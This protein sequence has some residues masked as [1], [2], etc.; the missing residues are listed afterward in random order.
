LAAG[1]DWIEAD[2][3]LHYGRLVARHDRSIWRLPITFSRTSVSLS[4]APPIVL[5]TLLHATQSTPARLL[6]DL[7]GR[8]ARLPDALVDLLRAQDAFDRVALCGQEWAL[9]DRAR[10]L[11]PHVKVIYSLGKPEHL[12][13]YLARRRDG[14]APS[15]SSCYHGLLTPARVAALNDAGSTVIAWTVDAEDRARQLLN[16]GVVGIT[17]NRLA[18]LSRLGAGLSDY[19]DERRLRGDVT[20][21]GRLGVNLPFTT[22]NDWLTIDRED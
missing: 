11:D 8:H 4:V 13:R 17:S 10:A 15:M 21:L 16:W 14:T 9:L 22:A 2:I 6:I 20:A 3:R 1:V 19:V 5:D 18:M 7:K 12:E